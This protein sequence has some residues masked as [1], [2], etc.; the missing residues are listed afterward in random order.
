MSYV[1]PTVLILT[2]ANLYWHICAALRWPLQA[3]GGT[4]PLH[5]HK[6]ITKPPPGGVDEISVVNLTRQGPNASI[7]VDPEDSK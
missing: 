4:D 1:S 6:K 3:H 5:F 7:R 2:V